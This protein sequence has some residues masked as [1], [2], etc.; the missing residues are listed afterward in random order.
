MEVPPTRKLLFCENGPALPGG[1]RSGERSLH[2]I[3]MCKGHAHVT[4]GGTLYM[5]LVLRH[6]VQLAPVRRA[7]AR[8]L[9]DLSGSSDSLARRA[10]LPYGV[11]RPLFLPSPGAARRRAVHG[12]QETA[13]SVRRRA[14]QAW[15]CALFPPRRCKQE[16][17][18]ACQRRPTPQLK[19]E[20]GQHVR[21]ATWE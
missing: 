13:S 20:I 8:T 12:R 11:R 9:P 6:G 17:K 10:G 21:G 3:L 5:P 7:S 1:R 18:L 19:D 16:C 2:L 4:G 15:S 14:R